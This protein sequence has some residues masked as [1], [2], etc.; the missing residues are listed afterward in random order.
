MVVRW[1]SCKLGRLLGILLI[2]WIL[3]EKGNIIEII[4]FVI[5]VINGVGIIFLSL[6]GM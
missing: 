4:V 5:N 1:G 2:W 6:V 3:F